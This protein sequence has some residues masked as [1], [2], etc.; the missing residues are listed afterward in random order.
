MLHF[1][2][3]L[4]VAYELSSRLFTLPDF[5]FPTWYKMQPYIPSRVVRACEKKKELSMWKKKDK[6]SQNLD[7]N[8][9]HKKCRESVRGRQSR[10][11]I[12]WPI[13]C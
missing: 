7:S 2:V 12:K 11:A 8:L 6:I 1:E 3:E 9:D 13:P 10:T 5:V 4:E